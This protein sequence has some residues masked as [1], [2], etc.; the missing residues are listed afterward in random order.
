VIA[1]FGPDQR[2]LGMDG[3]FEHIL[4]AIDFARF[5]AGRQVGAKPAHEH[6]GT[7]GHRARRLLHGQSHFVDH[8]V[9]RSNGLGQCSA[10]HRRRTWRAQ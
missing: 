6:G 1:V 5:L 8:V 4:E 10:T 7:I 9:L 3:V 2:Q